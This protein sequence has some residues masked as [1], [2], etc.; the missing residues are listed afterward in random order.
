MNKILLTIFVFIIFLIK[1]Q[2]FERLRDAKT[3]QV[4]KPIVPDIT[5]TG[6]KQVKNFF[7][8]FSYSFFKILRFFF[9]TLNFLKIFLKI[10]ILK[11]NLQILIYSLKINMKV[12]Y[13]F[14]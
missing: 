10:F 12:T 5:Y 6:I 7:P 8:K 11:H 9:L 4:L 1:S 2:A 14:K 3:E 13:F